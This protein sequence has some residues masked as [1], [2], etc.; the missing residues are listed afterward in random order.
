[1]TDVLTPDQRRLNMSR[2]RGKDTKPEMTLRRALHALGLRYRLH[3]RDMAGCPDLV[4]PRYKTVIF[5]HGCFWHGHRCHLFKKPETHT[6]FW[7][8]KISGNVDRDN[9]AIKVLRDEGWRVLMIW[10]CA[11]RGPR[12]MDLLKILRRVQQFLRGNRNVHEIEG[13][14]VDRNNRRW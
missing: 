7:L 11:L 3:R 10:E 13:V 12:R 4:F 8:K 9:K 2:V 1:M 5:V 6:D 14:G